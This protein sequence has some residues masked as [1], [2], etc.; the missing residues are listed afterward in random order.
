MFDSPI[1]R[2]HPYAV[3]SAQLIKGGN[4]PESSGTSLNEALHN[5]PGLIVAEAPVRLPPQQCLLT[6]ALVNAAH[7]YRLLHEGR[8]PPHF[9]TTFWHLVFEHFYGEGP[10]SDEDPRWDLLLFIKRGYGALALADEL[11]DRGLL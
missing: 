6:V 4:L 7:G 8:D 1:L 10:L 3:I 2:P 5:E 11:R 9:D